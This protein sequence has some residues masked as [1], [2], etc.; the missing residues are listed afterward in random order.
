MVYA[1]LTLPTYS[2]SVASAGHLSPLQFQARTGDVLNWNVAT[3]PAL[4]LM[5]G[6]VYPVI[7]KQVVP[8][9][10]ILFYTDGLTEAMNAENEQFTEERLVE[11]LKEKG[12]QSPSEVTQAL[13]EAVRKHRGEHIVTDDF[14]ILIAEIR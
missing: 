10:K 1:V 4:G 14:S 2:F 9:D 3:G 5:A 13:V 8:G 6:S 11:V 7:E 12:G